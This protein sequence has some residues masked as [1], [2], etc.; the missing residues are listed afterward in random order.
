[1]EKGI[2]LMGEAAQAYV[3]FKY[4]ELVIFGIIIG[5]FVVIMGIFVYK[6]IK[7]L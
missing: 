1:M 6:M 7:T 4:V 3:T 2:I 5:F